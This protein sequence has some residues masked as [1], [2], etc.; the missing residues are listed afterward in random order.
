[1]GSD[2]WPILSYFCWGLAIC[3]KSASLREPSMAK[4]VFDA[5]FYIGAV[6]FLPSIDA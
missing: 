4:K 1:M 5:Y 6:L 2:F 3:Y